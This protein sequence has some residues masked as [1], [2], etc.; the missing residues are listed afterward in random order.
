[1]TAYSGNLEGQTFRSFELDFKGGGVGPDGWPG[2]VGLWRTILSVKDGQAAYNLIHEAITQSGGRIQ[3]EISKEETL[4]RLER[5]AALYQDRMLTDD[6][7]RVAKA[8]LLG[9]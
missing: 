9:L 8:R 7:F 6:E 3:A 2:S 4:K 5:L 1:M